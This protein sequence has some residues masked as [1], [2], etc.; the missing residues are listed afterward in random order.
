MAEKKSTLMKK[1]TEEEPLVERRFSNTSKQGM[2]ISLNRDICNLENEI[3]KLESAYKKHEA[4]F[5]E[6]IANYR[7]QSE[8]VIKQSKE[9]KEAF[10]SLVK[11]QKRYYFNLLSDGVDVRNEGLVWVVK[12]LKEIN[13]DFENY[14]FPRFLD[15][16]QIDYLIKLASLMNERSQLKVILQAFKE[17]QKK[18]KEEQQDK[19]FSRKSKPE[20]EFKATIS[21]YYST[22]AITNDGRLNNKLINKLENN[23][24]SF[25]DDNQDREEEEKNIQRIVNEIKNVM[26][27]ENMWG[28]AD[29][30]L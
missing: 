14:M 8:Q 17:R 9:L 1:S 5:E 20:E 6:K 19:V 15:N 26:K 18:R 3:Y 7:L 23:F 10:N 2:P 29:V 4:K 30:A 12:R 11:H 25:H 22:N 16:Y 21:N 27:K 24:L 28:D 13:C